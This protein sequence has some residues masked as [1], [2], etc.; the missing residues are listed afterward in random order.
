MKAIYIFCCSCMPWIPTL[1]QIWWSLQPFY[2]ELITI[3]DPTIFWFKTWYIAI[4]L[5]AS[6]F[7]QQYLACKSWR[8]RKPAHGG[9]SQDSIFPFFAWNSWYLSSFISA[10]AAAAAYSLQVLQISPSLPQAVPWPSDDLSL[11]ISLNAG[12]FSSSPNAL[13]ESHPM[14]ACSLNR[15]SQ[16]FI[17]IT[18]PVY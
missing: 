7:I 2:W 1:F 6:F 10:I 18:N 12:T 14:K 15:P 13:T 4:I 17:Q 8:Y 3:H 11:I 9:S 16:I 5:Q